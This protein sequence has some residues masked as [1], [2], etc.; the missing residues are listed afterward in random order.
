MRLL[1]E[2]LTWKLT[3]GPAAL[4]YTFRAWWIAP[5]WGLSG[6]LIL[7]EVALLERYPQDPKTLTGLAAGFAALAAL[8]GLVGGGVLL[9]ATVF[10]AAHAIS[11]R[12]FADDDDGGDHPGEGD[13]D[14]DPPPSDGFD[15]WPQFE[16][17]LDVWQRQRGSL[18]A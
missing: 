18:V 9:F 7:L 10:G 1:S 14:R 12:L 17:E 8:S 3:L 5:W 2:F 15:W 16:R 11:L 6:P 4:H 13:D